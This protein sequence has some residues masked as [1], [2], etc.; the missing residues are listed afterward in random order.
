M[1]ITVN[2]IDDENV[3]AQPGKPVVSVITD[4]H[5]NI[6]AQSNSGGR[7][8]L[9]TLQKRKKWPTT[10]VIIRLMIASITAK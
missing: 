5:E 2:T 4:K 10:N 8:I 7:D 3:T 6:A 1:I 9:K